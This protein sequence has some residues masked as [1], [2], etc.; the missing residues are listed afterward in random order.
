MFAFNPTARTINP[1]DLTF[2]V[3]Y[4][5]KDAIEITNNMLKSNYTIEMS[6]LNSHSATVS[7]VTREY[8]HIKAVNSLC[9]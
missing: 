4:S 6:A 1:S 8:F 2:A 9:S 5:M 7:S 3:K